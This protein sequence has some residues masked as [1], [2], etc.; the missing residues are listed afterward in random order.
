MIKSILDTDLY[1]LTMQQAVCHLFPHAVVR[2]KFIDRG[3]FHCFTQDVVK[4]IEHAICKMESLALSNAEY[5]FLKNTCP[6]LN[7]VYLDFLKGYRFNKQE[8]DVYRDEYDNLYIDVEGPWY[9]TI[10]WEV[11]LLAIVSEI[12]MESRGFSTDKILED[13]KKFEALTVL[14]VNKMEENKAKFADFGTRRRFSYEMQDRVV[15][16]FSKF[17]NTFF[18]T[19]NV[20]LAMKHNTKPMGTQ[21]HEWFMF[22]GAHSGFNSANPAGLE[23]WVDVYQ[24]DLGIAL[25]DTFTFD[26]FL[27]SFTL[28]YAKLFDGLRHD[29]GDSFVFADKAVEHYLK[30]GIDPRSKT[31]VFSDSLDVEKAIKIKKYCGDRI[32]VSFGIGT[33]LT[34]DEAWTGT[35]SFNIVMKLDS[36]LGESSRWIP[37]VKLSDTEGKHTGNIEMVDLCKKTIKLM[38]GD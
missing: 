25:T 20:H 12:G 31:L 8:V 2:Y 28:K 38:K 9:R 7:P 23:K 32:N 24:G 1:K 14:K 37:V 15:S 17:P 10:L 33:N 26:A 3:S 21:A 11:P 18:G 6:F 13:Q 16:I 22:M 19:S 36:V 5:S 29:S 27:K 34:N 30:L 35:K 4:K